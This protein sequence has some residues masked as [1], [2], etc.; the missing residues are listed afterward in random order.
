MRSADWRIGVTVTITVMSTIVNN[1]LAPRWRE[2]GRRRLSSRYA[3][4][5]RGKQVQCGALARCSV[6]AAR[7]AARRRRPPRQTGIHGRQRGLG[8]RAKAAVSVV[9]VGRHREYHIDR[10]IR[11]GSSKLVHARERFEKDEGNPSLIYYWSGGIF[12][13][14][15]S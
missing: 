3:L 9:V 14:T 8:R 4:L 1:L 10:H 2:N 11:H 5:L 15:E 13:V 7:S 12:S 6:D